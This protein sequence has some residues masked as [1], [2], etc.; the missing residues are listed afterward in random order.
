MAPVPV[1][2]EMSVVVEVKGYI[3]VVAELC[4]AADAES[5]EAESGS[6]TVLEG[7]DE[8]AVKVDTSTVLPD[9][10]TEATTETRMVGEDDEAER[11]VPVCRR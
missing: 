10:S 4:G 8:L 7:D 1:P 2:E 6:V 5:L 9:A 11:P 3:G